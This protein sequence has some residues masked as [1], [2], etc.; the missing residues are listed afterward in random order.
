MTL[1]FASFQLT[2][3]SALAPRF[4]QCPKMIEHIHERVRWARY[5]GLMTMLAVFVSSKTSL[6]LL[7]VTIRV[8]V[9]VAKPRVSAV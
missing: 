6:A 5:V 7:A 3:V 2:A 1:L 9:E 8:R 4:V